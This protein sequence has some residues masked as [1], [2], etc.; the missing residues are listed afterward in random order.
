MAGGSH[1]ATVHV[2]ID[3]AGAR[4]EE[5]PL[6]PCVSAILGVSMSDTSGSVCDQIQPGQDPWPGTAAAPGSL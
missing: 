1:Y 6:P 2:G 4:R 5:T 3:T